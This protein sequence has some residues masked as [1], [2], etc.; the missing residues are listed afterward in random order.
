MVWS[1]AGAKKTAQC[2]VLSAGANFKIADPIQI[3]KKW[4]KFTFSKKNKRRTKINFV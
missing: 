4:S 2:K 3:F 1:I